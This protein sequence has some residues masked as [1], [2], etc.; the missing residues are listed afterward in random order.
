MADILTDIEQKTIDRLVAKGL[1]VGKVA[2]QAQGT[3]TFVDASANVAIV[4][5]SFE[6]KGQISFRCDANLYVV[7]KFTSNR[8]E[9]DRRKGIYPIVLAVLSMLMLQDLGL[10]ITPLV[11]VR[12]REITGE[13]DW[14]NGQILYMLQFKTSFALE[15]VDDEAAVDLLRLGL[16]VYLQDVPD[17]TA[18]VISVITLP[19]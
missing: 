10:Q 8:S 7:L 16:S 17:D 11:P 12:F 3:K 5:G 4:D 19:A 15:M 6:Q 2:A 9:E 18:E 1:P 13:E 14:K